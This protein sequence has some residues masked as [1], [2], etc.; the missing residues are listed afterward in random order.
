MN[1]KRSD[2][3]LRAWLRRDPE[4]AIESIF[5][6]HFSLVCQTIYQII[7][8]PNR[9][10]D[11]AQEVF[12]ELWRRRKRLRIDTS[13]PAYLRRA[14]INKSLNELRAQKINFAEEEQIP[15]FRFHH[16]PR[17]IA[18]E[19]ELQE[20]VDAAVDQLPPRCR[21]IFI[22]SR[23][24]ELNQRAIARELNISVKT[25]ENQINKALRLLR[26]ALGPYLSGS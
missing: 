26:E 25:V 5:K 23:Y 18:Q 9:V 14:A 7:P 20:L 24:E 16:V 8:D 21:I 3:E 22:L 19:A 17:D 10:E 12:L 11:I 4:A 1:T 2:R 15:E 6:T 13:L